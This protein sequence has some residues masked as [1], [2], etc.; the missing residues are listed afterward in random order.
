[1]KI[2][3][4]G[5]KLVVG[6]R[7]QQRIAEGLD[8]IGKLL[9]AGCSAHVIVVA[10]KNRRMVEISVKSR[11]R[12]F[13][14]SSEAPEV[15]PALHATLRKIEQQAIRHTKKRTTVKRH[16]HAEEAGVEV[17]PAAAEAPRS[18]AV[19]ARRSAVSRKPMPVVVHS[20]PSR[21]AQPEPHVVRSRDAV[22]LRPMSLEEAVKEAEF[23][24][25]EVFVFR[26]Y[27]GQALVLHR[28]RDGKMELIEVP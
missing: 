2:E 26:N 11:S 5:R 21:T 8:P 24:D 20:F 6:K 15:E 14:A 23:R 4:T 27:E 18:P 17:L 3:Y 28:K 9:G 7:L 19:A 13:V 1:M 25:R 12:G 16:A 10:E 22:A